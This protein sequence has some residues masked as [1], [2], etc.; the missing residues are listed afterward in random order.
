MINQQ[1]VNFIK[2]QLQVGVTKEK[3]SSELLANG[4]NSQDIEEGFKATGIPIPS[5][6]F[7]NTTPV[8]NP[9]I[10]P[11][12][13]NNDNLTSFTTKKQSGKKLF[14]IILL[15]LFLLVGGASAY[16]FKDNLINL[17]IIKDFF[18]N[19]ETTVIP[20][21]PIQT[22]NTQIVTQTQP[23]NT[24]PTTQPDNSVT[25]PSLS[26]YNDPN[27]LYSFS[28][29]KGMEITHTGK[30][31]MLNLTFKKDDFIP[32]ISVISDVNDK[33]FNELGG[34]SQYKKS[35]FGSINTYPSYKYLT[36]TSKD[37]PN[38]YT[39]IYVIDLGSYN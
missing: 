13:N 9:N 39:A 2:Q 30:Y 34:K 8:L 18:P 4:W 6:P 5:T 21:V 22:D 29:P 20:E 37:L 17:P 16:F 11:Y 33:L 35:F 10:S 38:L 1:L 15:I 26:V 32:L 24:T 7:S 3:I 14:F 12:I 28:Y 23:N 27:G 31:P 36:D 19:Q 25:D